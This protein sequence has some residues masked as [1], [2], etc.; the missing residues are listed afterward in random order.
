MLDIAHIAA[1]AGSAVQRAEALLDALS[2]LLPF[3]ASCVALLHPTR[4]E[5]LSLVRSGYD[6]RTCAYCDDPAWME[7]I[8]LVG[9]QRAR[10]PMRVCDFPV[11][12]EE[13]Y[14][15]A[16][17]L[18]P[19]GFREGLGV[20][21]F[22]PDGRYLG[23]LGLN[24]GSPVPATDAVRD[25]VGMLAPLLAHAVDPM[26]EVG[27]I[28]GVVHDA[29]AGVVLTGSGMVLPL[30]GLPAHPLLTVDSPVLG[31]VGA[32]WSTGDGRPQVSFLCPVP[33]EDGAEGHLRVTV[34]SIPPGVPPYDVTAVVVMSPPGDLHG[35]TP[36]ELEVLG[37]LVEGWP[38]QAI[39]ADLGITERTVAAHVEHILTK[40][41]VTSRTVAAVSALRLGL[42]VPRL[43]H[44]GTLPAG[45]GAR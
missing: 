24:T 22:T 23:L 5:H 15:W 45:P 19:A 25:L 10:P 40:L 21:L 43:L 29:S 11:P 37:L 12:P 39:A 8:E 3:D 35:L 16:E 33:A 44:H 17:Y 36:R 18:V 14:G 38:N 9:L 27:A 6:D 41:A 42:F 28:A 34:L 13:V 31:V 7:D 2:R 1:A 4:R 30:P 26:R 32:A 20:G